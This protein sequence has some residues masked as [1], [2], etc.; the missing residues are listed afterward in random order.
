MLSETTPNLA[1]ST[2]RWPLGL[3]SFPSWV[4][5][6]PPGA[7][8]THLGPTACPC[9]AGASWFAFSLFFFFLKLKCK[10]KKLMLGAAFLEKDAVLKAVDHASQS[11]LPG[12]AG[13][14]G[15]TQHE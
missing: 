8:E 5:P 4:P 9:D 15:K 2:P 14:F 13:S 1:W 11:L 3:A 10:V 6:T 12:G 7:T